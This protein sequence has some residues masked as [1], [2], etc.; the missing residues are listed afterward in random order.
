MVARR[1]ER[2]GAL[3]LESKPLARPDPDKQR[4]AM[5]EGIRRIGLDALPWS[6]EA[7]QWRARAVSARVAP[8][9][10]CQ[11]RS[12]G[13]PEENWPD[14]SD[15]ALLANIE[16]WLGPYLDGVTRRDHLARLDVLSAL[17]SLLDWN[18]AKRLDENAP[19]HLTVPSGSSI[20]ALSTSP[21][22]HRCW[23]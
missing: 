7:R 21:V 4:A 19:T 20:C 1:E 11:C 22:S 12:M 3:L 6:P 8:R 16:T 23:R 14:V 17:K 5:L 15:A 2:F 13:R 18:Q 9:R 10:V